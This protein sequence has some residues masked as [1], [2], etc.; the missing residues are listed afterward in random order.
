MRAAIMS[1]ALLLVCSIAANMSLYSTATK[2]TADARS[3][4]YI[5]D[6][7][8]GS[9]TLLVAVTPEGTRLYRVDAA[10]MV[11]PA[12]IAVSSSGQIAIR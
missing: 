3:P 9:T 11:V 5:P 7:P 4:D 1:L 10:Q 2:R 6:Q 12:L 8:P